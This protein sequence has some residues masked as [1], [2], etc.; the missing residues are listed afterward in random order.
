MLRLG[1]IVR[2]DLPALLIYVFALIPDSYDFL[3][4]IVDTMMGIILLSNIHQHE[5]IRFRSTLNLT[6]INKPYLTKFSK[7]FFKEEEVVYI[8]AAPPS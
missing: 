4:V 8:W 6:S 2:K 7:E 1:S 5:G 3:K